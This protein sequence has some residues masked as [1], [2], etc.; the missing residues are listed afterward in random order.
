MALTPG[1]LHH[2]APAF[3]GAPPCR[4][5]G[6][7]RHA[8]RDG[9]RSAGGSKGI[10]NRGAA[11][12]VH[13]SDKVHVQVHAR[14]QGRSL[15]G[16]RAGAPPSSRLLACL[17]PSLQAAPRPE[18]SVWRGASRGLLSRDSCD[19][20]SCNSFL[21]LI[22]YYTVSISRSVAV[23]GTCMVHE[24][25]MH[26]GAIALIYDVCASKSFFCSPDLCACGA[27]WLYC[28]SWLCVRCP[29]SCSCSVRVVLRS[30]PRYTA[31]V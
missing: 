23:C 7:A 25:T 12:C 1:A 4:A 15:H 11:R 19:R 28:C 26:G 20:P 16:G 8:D 30:A 17:P 31:A 13:S 21:Q 29:L 6:C 24:R 14:F 18:G 27:R 5:L 2:P 9:Q 3:A 22:S 10:G